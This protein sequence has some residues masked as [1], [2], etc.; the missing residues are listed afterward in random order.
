MQ[1]MLKRKPKNLT[2]EQEA[3]D[4]SL[5]L[6]SYRDYSNKDMEMKLKRKGVDA[7][8][9]QTTIKKLLEYGFLNER[10]YAQ[11]VFEAWLSKRYYGRTHLQVE[12]QKK[13]VASKYINE[14]LGQLS[15]TMEQERAENALRSCLKKNSKKYSTE[16]PEGRAAISRFLY[17][18]GFSIHYIKKSINNIHG[19][20]IVM[21][22]C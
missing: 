17:T 13:N 2:T 4:Y 21:D 14:I 8:I 16:T 11:R 22:D 6:L 7:E 3:Y 20:V 19:S 10:R 18:R 12:L 5:K 1:R 15:E 9:I